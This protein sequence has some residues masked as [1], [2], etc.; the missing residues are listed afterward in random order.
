MSKKLSSG[1]LISYD[2]FVR[3][4]EEGASPHEVLNSAYAKHPEISR[5]DRN[6]IKELLFGSLRW[7]SKIF[8]ILQKTSKR[9]LLTVKPEVRAALVLGT[10]QIFYMDKVPDRA[11]VNESVE[12]IRQKGQAHATGFINGILRSISR[13]SE[14]FAKPDKKKKPCEYLALQYAHPEWLIRSWLMRFHFEKVKTILSANNHQPPLTIRIN[15][16]KVALEDIAS[17]KTELLKKERVKSN[18]SH[19]D[20]CVSLSEFPRMDKD[21]FFT[22]GYFTIQDESS[23]LISNLVNPGENEK[24]LDACAGLGGKTGHIFELAPESASVVALDCSDYR[25][26]K[27]KEAF[28]RMGHKGIDYVLGDLL[29]YEAEERFDKILLDS[30]CSGFGVLRRHPEGKWQKK[31]D[32]VFELAK[33]QRKLIDKALEL[34]KPGGE[35]IF[36]VCSFELQESV[37]HLTY[38]KEEKNI[39]VID[40][41]KRLPPYYSKYI[42]K[43]QVLMIYPGNKENMDGFSSFAIKKIG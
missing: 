20:Y 12:Y 24:I 3:V 22:K 19:L 11:A 37:D 31:A 18:F 39:K 4:F 30:P 8:W 1:R 14:Y 9:D 16:K 5:L 27:A 40:I 42:T 13:K 25:V 10:Y 15:C 2:A 41:S 29:E 38:L 7:Y 23:Q 6:F 17:F 32:T 33:K 34:L 35:L 28:E 21:S 26:R 43:D 36:S